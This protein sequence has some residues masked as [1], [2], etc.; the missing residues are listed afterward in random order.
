MQKNILGQLRGVFGAKSTPLIGVDISS[1]SV[2]LVELAGTRERP[3]LSRYTIEPLPRDAVT[4]GNI[5]NLE[6]VGAALERAPKAGLTYQSRCGGPADQHGD[7]QTPDIAGH[8]ARRGH[9]ARR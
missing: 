7:H 6:A 5:A 3:E 4:D 1:T 9:G 8:R 2:K